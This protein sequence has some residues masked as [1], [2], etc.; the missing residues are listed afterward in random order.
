M[1]SRVVVDTQ[2]IMQALGY[3]VEAL[4]STANDKLQQMMQVLSWKRI[5]KAI[6]CPQAPWCHVL[7][8]HDGTLWEVSVEE[9]IVD[10]DVLVAHSILAILNLHNTVNQQ[11]WVPARVIKGTQRT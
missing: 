11:E 7:T 2:L 1:Q 9:L 6:G 8:W 5:V 3:P 4:L 10:C